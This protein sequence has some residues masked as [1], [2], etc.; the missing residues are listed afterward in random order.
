MLSV[1]WSSLRIDSSLSLC[2]MWK[3]IFFTSRKNLCCVALITFPNENG[4]SYGSHTHN[5]PFCK[6]LGT[7]CTPPY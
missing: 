2:A 7:T 1:K 3:V 4:N 5:C 6:H